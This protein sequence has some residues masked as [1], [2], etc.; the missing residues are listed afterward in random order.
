MTRA[1]ANV[2]NYWRASGAL[3]ALAACLVV[4]VSGVAHAATPAA[5]VTV[6]Y[7]DLNLTTT[8]GNKE[9]YARIVSAARQVC[10]AG[11][12]SIRNLHAFAAEQSCEARAIAQAVRDTNNPVL[13][14]I[15][16]T[17]PHHG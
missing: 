14:A 6:S 4:G 7:S 10:G 11:E 8:A 2:S 16:S 17:R 12:V 3:T 13:A 1:I 9:L 5:S 15:Y